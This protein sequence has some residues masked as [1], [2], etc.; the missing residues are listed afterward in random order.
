MLLREISTLVELFSYQHQIGG[1]AGGRSSAEKK[2]RHFPAASLCFNLAELS[3]SLL[4]LTR[5]AF[6]RGGLGSKILKVSP[7]AALRRFSHV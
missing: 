1:C 7:D 3:S 6:D 5:I 4:F 2:G